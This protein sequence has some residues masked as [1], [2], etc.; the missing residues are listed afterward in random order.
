MEQSFEDDG[1]TNHDEA[2]PRSGFVKKLRQQ[3]LDLI[4][5]ETAEGRHGTIYVDINDTE[6]RQLDALRSNVHNAGH[7]SGDPM[8]AAVIAPCGR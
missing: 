5:H 2:P 1:A 3:Q 6:R 4:Q 7:V 8:S